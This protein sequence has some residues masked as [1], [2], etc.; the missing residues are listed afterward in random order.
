MQHPRAPIC[1]CRHKKHTWNQASDFGDPPHLGSAPLTRWHLASLF[2]CITGSTALAWST[3]AGKTFLSARIELKGEQEEPLSLCSR[4]AFSG[5]R[6]RASCEGMAWRGEGSWNLGPFPGHLVLWTAPTQAKTFSASMLGPC[7]PQTVQN[8]LLDLTPWWHPAGQVQ[9]LAFPCL[10]VSTHIK[11]DPLGAPAALQTEESHVEARPAFHSVTP[12]G[13]MCPQLLCRCLEAREHAVLR[14]CPNSIT[15]F[16]SSRLDSSFFHS[17][18]GS[19][20]NRCQVSGKGNR[21][22]S[23]RLSLRNLPVWWRTLHR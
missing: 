14:Q 22:E 17:T 23:C 10:A 5:C 4:V 8:V 20:S 9:A 18:T 19:L 6:S 11:F 7:L 16:D 15:V 12:L 3:H 1:T 13:L 2:Q 21:S